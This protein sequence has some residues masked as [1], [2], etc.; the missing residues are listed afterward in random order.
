MWCV[1]LVA[2]L[3]L[4][5]PTIVC[6]RNSVTA[7]EPIF[8]LPPVTPTYFFS[9]SGQNDGESVNVLSCVGART[10]HPFA[11]RVEFCQADRLLGGRMLT[12]VETPVLID[13]SQVPA[14]LQTITARFYTLI[15]NLVGSASVTALVQHP[16][17]DAQLE[18][19]PDLSRVIQLNVTPTIGATS[20]A[21]LA[22]ADSSTTYSST[23]GIWSPIQLDNA[24]VLGQGSFLTPSTGAPITAN[25]VVPSSVHGV[26][27]NIAVLVL[28]DGKWR[29]SIVRSVYLP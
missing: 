14:G 29:S 28:V 2:L 16:T 24:M 11:A 26:T 20:Y 7:L 10:N 25:P 18:I 22:R 21:V 13:T 1:S 23:Y 6:L 12:G 15:G 17:L 4:S 8:L 3:L 5:I 27:W 19:K 9:I